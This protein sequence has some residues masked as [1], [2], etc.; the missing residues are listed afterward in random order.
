MHGRYN[1]G[2]G[3][4]Y[5]VSTP[6][7]N[8]EDV[9]ARA[10]RVLGEVAAVLSEDTRRTGILLKHLGVRTALFSLHEHNEASR[11]DAVL[12]RLDGG[13][14]LALVSDAGTPLVSDPGARLVEAIVEAGHDVVPVPGPSA[15]MAALVGSGLAGDGFTFLGFAPRKGK[16]RTAFL[17][18]MADTAHPTV[19]FESPER[20]AALLRDLAEICGEGRRVAV[21]REL[22]KLYETFFRGTLADAASYYDE[23][24]PRGE[25]TVVLEGGELSGKPDAA[26]TEAAR[27]LAGTLMD[28]G[29]KSSQAAREVARRLR[30][31]RN[32]AYEIVQSL[33]DPPKG[34][35]S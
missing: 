29:H 12:A 35:D 2:M 16:E 7:G 32:L 24:P 31:P 13:D 20:L 27:I 21:G 23:S 30:L 6:I 10:A 4:L 22:T 33:T 5:I 26:D 8:L 25:V 9:T 34:P 18:R 14:D 3:T 1:S 11:V 28:R 15:V 19:S 17:E